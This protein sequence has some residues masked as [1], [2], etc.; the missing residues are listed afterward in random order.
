M[1]TWDPINNPNDP[2]IILDM[3]HPG[4]FDALV[5]PFASCILNGREKPGVCT[6]PPRDGGSYEFAHV[7]PGDKAII[8]MGLPHADL[9][10]PASAAA[11]HYADTGY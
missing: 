4:S 10:L 1:T 8:P 2:L 9:S 6:P 5:A 11:Q 3:R 7:G